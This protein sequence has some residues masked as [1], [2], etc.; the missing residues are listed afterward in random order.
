LRGGRVKRYTRDAAGQV[1]ETLKP[2]GAR[3]SYGYDKSGL[4]KRIETFGPDGG[5]EDVARFWYDGR[6]LLVQA[7]SGAA[8]IELERDR[9]GRIIDETV[10][11]QRVKSKRD[12]SGLRIVRELVGIGGGLSAYVRDPLE[13]VE[14]LTSGDAAFD[15][16]RD[17][18][19]HETGRR[20]G[21]GF[22]L[23]QRFD[24]AGQLIE[25]RAGSAQT[26]RPSVSPLGLNLPTPATADSAPQAR[27]LYAYDR[28]FAPVKI[29]DALWGE[30][31]F[32]HDGNGQIASADGASGTERFQYDAA[33]NV[34]GASAPSPAPAMAARA[35]GR[36]P[37]TT[38]PRR[39]AAWSR[40]RG[41][42][43]ASA[44]GSCT[45]PAGG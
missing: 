24:P 20:F 15:F 39:P 18:F 28:A 43:R 41:G 33:R 32:A 4:L 13:A 40:S 8:L 7:E 42:R 3:L 19:G 36:R 30:T 14:R 16:S 29:D 38:G 2:D 35:T 23:T 21:S 10:N 25:Q 9:D 12:S 6:G 34:V 5:P 11:G 37:L 27:R 26:W 1:T 31:R 22:E 17:A 44:S 45:M